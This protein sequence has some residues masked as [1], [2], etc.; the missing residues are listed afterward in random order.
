MFILGS[1]RKF[2]ILRPVANFAHQSLL[3]C[4]KSIDIRIKLNSLSYF[5]PFNF[6][7]FSYKESIQVGPFKETKLD[8]VSFINSFTLK[9]QNMK[10]NI[11]CGLCKENISLY[12]YSSHA[13]SCLYRQYIRKSGKEYQCVICQIKCDNYVQH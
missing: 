10:G 1:K 13:S 11:E 8:P 12:N 3:T 5:S 4:N 2:M 6:H 7:C 9:Q